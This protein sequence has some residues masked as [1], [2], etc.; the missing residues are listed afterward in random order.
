MSLILQGFRNGSLG[1]AHNLLAKYYWY[2]ERPNS[3]VVKGAS[4]S[5]LGIRK[6][7]TGGK[8]PATGAAEPRQHAVIEDRRPDY[9]HQ[10]REEMVVV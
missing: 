5:W 3:M 9:M 7:K 1:V 6:S 8:M 2:K 4:R 10:G